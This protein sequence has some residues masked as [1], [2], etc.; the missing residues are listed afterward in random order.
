MLFRADESELP[1]QKLARGTRH[2][3]AALR[4]AE[5]QSKIGSIEIKADGARFSG[6]EYADT[7]PAWSAG[8]RA[9]LPFAFSAYAQIASE[10]RPASLLESEGDGSRIIPSGDLRPEEMTHLEVGVDHDD[11]SGLASLHLAMFHD[12]RQD[13]I[14]IVPSSISSYR[15]INLG[16]ASSITGIEFSFEKSWDL[17]KTGALRSGASWV[18]FRSKSGDGHNLLIPGVPADQGAVV[19]SQP[20]FRRQGRSVA[21]RWTSRRRGLVYRDVANDVL[22][23][24]WWV[25]DAALDVKW[26]CDDEGIGS[27]PVDLDVGFAVTNGGSG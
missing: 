5:D 15:A 26:R 14:V 27:R 6:G 16:E 1:S 21:A 24:P 2:A 25:H 12:D 9:P 23:P 22:V 19:F 7:R 20:L 11:Q 4:I 13:A 18:W 8:W 3:V 10:M 17:L